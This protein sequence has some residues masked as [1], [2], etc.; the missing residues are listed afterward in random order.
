MIGVGIILSE[1]SHLR[2]SFELC[3]ELVGVR[4]ELNACILLLGLR[5]IS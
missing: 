1:A 2:S 4:V 3:I 5:R